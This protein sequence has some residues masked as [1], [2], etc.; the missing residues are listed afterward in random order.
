MKTIFFS[1]ITNPMSDKEMK[2]TRGGYDDV[3]DDVQSNFDP[4]AD[5]TTTNNCPSNCDG[6][7]TTNGLSGKCGWTYVPSKHCTCATVT[8][9]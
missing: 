4:T 3:Q 6:S 8:I 2:N 5:G 1:G 9:G 7:C